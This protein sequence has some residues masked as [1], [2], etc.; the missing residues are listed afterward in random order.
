MQTTDQKRA[1]GV[2]ADHHQAEQSLSEL[3]ESGF[4]M[5][6]VSIVVRQADGDEEVKGA[7]VSDRIGDQDVKTPLGAAKEAFASGSLGFVLVGLGSL[8]LPGIGPLLAAGSLGA[9]LVA[10]TAG[11]GVGALAARNLAKTFSDLGIPEAKAS[12]Y[13]DRL[14][15]G[16]CL[17]MVE[18]NPDEVQ[19]A[20]QVFSH[21]GIQDW[22]IY[23]AS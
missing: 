19:S 20:E 2:F 4:P 6:H 11:A 17:V 12:V 1:L 10:T 13:S 18:G 3:K 5:D 7:E 23:A 8:A 15:Q 21:Q 9:A 16:D 22:G 14:M